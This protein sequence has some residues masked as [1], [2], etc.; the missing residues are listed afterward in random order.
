MTNKA[1]MKL[2]GLPSHRPES[3]GRLFARNTFD[4]TKMIFESYLSYPSWSGL[5]DSTSLPKIY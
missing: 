1:K 3:Y 4:L 5:V 2:E